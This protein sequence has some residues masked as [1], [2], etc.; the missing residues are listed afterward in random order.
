MLIGNNVLV[1]NGRERAWSLVAHGTAKNPVES[2][3]HS[4]QRKSIGTYASIIHH[5]LHTAEIGQHRCGFCQPQEVGLLDA[6]GTITNQIHFMS[7][8][9]PL[10][11][12]RATWAGNWYSRCDSWCNTNGR[13]RVIVHSSCNSLSGYHYM[14][15]RWIVRVPVKVL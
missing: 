10:R 5:C 7:I 14:S 12:P 13:W 9:H 3:L 8:K 4:H 6:W 15:Y 2:A 11:V 1:V